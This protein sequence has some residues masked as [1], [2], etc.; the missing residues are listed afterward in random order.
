MK[1]TW[2]PTTAREWTLWE[3]IHNAV[4][5]GDF[6]N[7]GVPVDYYP[8]GLILPRPLHNLFVRNDLAVIQRQVI[9]YLATVLAYDP[10]GEKF[11]PAQVF[12]PVAK[13]AQQAQVQL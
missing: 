4:N 10:D 13:M 8:F 3:G 12:P 9:A 1:L 6:G 11:V 2:Y 7:V 5:K